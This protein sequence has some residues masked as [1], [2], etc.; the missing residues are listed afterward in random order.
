MRVH[1]LRSAAVALVATIASA[2]AVFVAPSAGAVVNGCHTSTTVRSAH[3]L[4]GNAIG[5]GRTQGRWC[6]LGVVG[7]ASRLGGWAETS[8]P[9]WTASGLLGSNAGVANGE[10]RSWSMFKLTLGT[11]WLTLQ[12][13]TMCPRVRGTV[14]A[15]NNADN[16]CSIW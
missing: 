5:T 1:V 13:I 11:T 14:N 15:T 10:G 2:T 8:T 16:A 12:E 9:G 4:A 3:A 6:V 7:N